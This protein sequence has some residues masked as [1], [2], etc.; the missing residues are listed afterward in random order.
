MDSFKKY[1]K[2]VYE[3]E[4]RALDLM[5]HGGIIEEGVFKL[6]PRALFF[7]LLAALF[8]MANVYTIACYDYIAKIMCIIY[9]AVFLQ[10]IF[11]VLHELTLKFIKKVFD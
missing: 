5:G 3:W 8:F 9:C 4:C 10:V 11:I 1:T 2:V 6:N 7:Y